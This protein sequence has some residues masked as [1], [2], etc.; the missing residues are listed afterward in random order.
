[1]GD[2]INSLQGQ[3]LIASPHMDDTRF[4]RSVIMMCQHDAQSA[5]GLVINKQAS[6]LKLGDLFEKL[7]I[8]APRFAAQNPV[9]I[10]GPVDSNR[11]FVLHSQDHMLPDSIQVTH[12]IG[13]TASID[14][15]RD[16]TEGIGPAQSI[17]SLGCAGWG[18]GQL[19]QEISENV[20]LNLP[21]SA[22]LV[23]DYDRDTLWEQGFTTLGIDPG[24][25]AGTAG[26]A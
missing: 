23:F 5:M 18:A 22:P 10:G 3:L 24:F 14:I 21:A 1:M 11:G 15:L 20:W 4:Q 19:D 12:D 6:R 17:V 16:I 25:F 2:N 7:D 9:H 26:S 8:G 13:L